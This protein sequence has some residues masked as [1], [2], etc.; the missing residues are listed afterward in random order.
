MRNSVL[1]TMLIFAILV[2]FCL[3]QILDL[4]LR[5]IFTLMLTVVGCVTVTVAERS[6]CNHADVSAQY[7]TA[8]SAVSTVDGLRDSKSCGS[9]DQFIQAL[10][11]SLAGR[12]NASDAATADD[13]D[14][15]DIDDDDGHRS[16]SPVL[17]MSD[18]DGDCPPVISE[19]YVTHRSDLLQCS[20][21]SPALSA[22]ARLQHSHSFQ[23]LSAIHFI[24]VW[25]KGNPI[26]ETSVGF[27][28]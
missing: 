10:T 24:L 13:D 1:S 9:D 22:I 7:S 5:Y 3:K 18:S 23:V 20:T 25:S 4:F 12:D 8:V 19:S 21:A 6:S 26:L 27:R 15:D 17:S 16:L 28:S 14:D 11:S 2:T